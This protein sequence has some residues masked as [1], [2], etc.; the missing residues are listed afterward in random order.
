MGWI[1][2]HIGIEGNEVADQ[3]AKEATGEEHTR[4]M[5]VPFADLEKIL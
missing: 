2:A 5:E 3:L 1:P 4:D